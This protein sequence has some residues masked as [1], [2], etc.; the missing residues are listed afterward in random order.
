MQAE[1]RH[2][3][4]RAVMACNKGKLFST[5]HTFALAEPPARLALTAL[6]VLPDSLPSSFH[7]AFIHQPLAKP[8]LGARHQARGWDTQMNGTPSLP[9]RISLASMELRHENQ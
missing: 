9:S 3:G 5:A 2:D 4:W 8:V 1:H 6:S 7:S